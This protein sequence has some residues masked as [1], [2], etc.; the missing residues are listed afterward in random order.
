MGRA[1][2]KHLKDSTLLT[3][4]QIC[5]EWGLQRDSTFT[6]NSMEGVIRFTNGSEIYLKDLFAYP[7]DPEFDSFGSTEFTGAFVDEGSQIGEKAKN[8]LTARLRYRHQELGLI[9]KLLIGSNPSKNFLYYQFYK[10]WKENTLPA[11]RRFVRAFV[12]DNP[13]LP[14]Q[15]VEQLQRLDKNSRERLLYG[16]FEYDDDPAKL[17][18]FDKINDL[19]TNRPPR[20]GKKYITCDVARFGDDRT[21]IFVW[22]GMDVIRLQ[23]SKHNS[24]QQTRIMLEALAQEHTIPRSNIIVDEDGIGGG[25]VDEMNGIRGFVNNSSPFR[26]ENYSNLKSQCYFYLADR[27][28]KGQIG[29]SAEISTQ[30]RERIVEDL[31]QARK[32]DADKDGK[33]ALVPKNEI[34]ERIGRSP[35]YG[36][37]LAM[38]M[39]FEARGNTESRV[40]ARGWYG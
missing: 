31:E 3:F 14:P 40:A 36:D 2:L 27:V 29:I 7:S 8:I 21:V 22:D 39:W 5:K 23:T 9:P 20:T 38:R 15:Y 25:V 6:Y 26:E 13:H 24:T 11:H 34:K 17:M 19:F 12:G 1:V 10:P 28:N 30:D 4:F 16:N 32:K 35:D 18:E 33:L 37:A